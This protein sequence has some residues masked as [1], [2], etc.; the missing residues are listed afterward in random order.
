MST[1]KGR[2]LANR[3]LRGYLPHDPSRNLHELDE[4][5]STLLRLGNQWFHNEERFAGDSTSAEE[6][7]HTRLE[8]RQ[9]SIER[10]MSEVWVID[11]HPPK[12]WR[13]VFDGLFARIVTDDEREIP[14]ADD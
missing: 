5:C 8:K 1:Q 10:R 14:L 12:G 4:T 2:D 3:L 6:P 11:F 9:A 7:E 13:L